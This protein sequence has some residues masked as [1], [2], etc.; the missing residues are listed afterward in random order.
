MILPTL[1]TAVA[2]AVSPTR[3]SFLLYL[4]PPL[5]IIVDILSPGYFSYKELGNS[6]YAL[7]F[8]RLVYREQR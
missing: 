7:V 6:G 1:P 8:T 4:L 5:Y 2:V 3:L